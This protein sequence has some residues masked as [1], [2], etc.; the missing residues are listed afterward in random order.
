MRF[1]LLLLLIVCLF[2]LTFGFAQ[3]KSE[4]VKS[5]KT[6]TGK[7]VAFESGDYLHAVIKD[8]KGEEV[9]FFI[10]GVGMDFFLAT[11]AKKTGTFTYQEVEVYMEEA[12]GRITIARLSKAKVGKETDASWW[13]AQRKKLSLDAINKKYQPAVD[14]LIRKGG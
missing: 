9:S 1:R 4:K 5:T 8:S 13:A 7:F 6:I 12:G 14:K 10:G 11:H 3:D 2:G